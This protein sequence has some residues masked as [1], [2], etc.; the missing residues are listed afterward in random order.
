MMD[1]RDI[2]NEQQYEKRQ[3]DAK[4]A[5]ISAHSQIV[6]DTAAFLKGMWAK[7]NESPEY[8]AKFDELDFI[9]EFRYDWCGK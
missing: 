5:L 6:E 1:Y 2:M 8:Y 7:I 3:A 4:D 9:N